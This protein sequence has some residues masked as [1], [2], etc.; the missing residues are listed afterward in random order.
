MVTT[1]RI[2]WMLATAIILA[3]IYL[4][5]HIGLKVRSREPAPPPK[6]SL[7]QGVDVSLE[8]LQ[9]SEVRDGVTRWELVAERADNDRQKEITFLSRPVMTVPPSR[10]NGPLTLKADKAEYDNRSRDVR[11]M[12][13]VVVTGDKGAVLRTGRA[14]YLSSLDKIRTT[15]RVHVQQP[16]LTVSGTGMELS[17]ETRNVRLLSA[18]EAVVSSSPSPKKTGNGSRRQR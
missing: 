5:V 12:G 3:C 8:Q 6:A 18:V 11:L 1:A 9:F 13:N 17:T 4:A 16:G 7:P 15:D 10:G 14:E 2:K